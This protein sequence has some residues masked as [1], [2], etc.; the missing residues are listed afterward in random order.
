MYSITPPPPVPA[1]SGVPDRSAR[2][3]AEFS[4]SASRSGS[5]SFRQ[6]K[7]IGDE[8]LLAA[9]QVRR[10]SLPRTTTVFSG[11]AMI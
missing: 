2:T 8:L 6:A 7:V 11:C 4:V 10:T 1:T 9:L 5:W 3:W